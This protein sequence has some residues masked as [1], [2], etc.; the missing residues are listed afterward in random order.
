MTT[1]GKKKKQ[2]I[3]TQSTDRGGAVTLP[4]GVLFIAWGFMLLLGIS[5]QTASSSLNLF[6]NMAIGLGGGL[7][8]AIPI[9]VIWFGSLLCVSA[10]RRVSMYAFSICFLLLLCLQALMTLLLR[11]NDR[12]YPDLMSYIRNLNYLRNAIAPES[13]WEYISASYNRYYGRFAGNAFF[14]GGGAL[15]MLFAWPLH[16]AFGNVGAAVMLFILIAALILALLRLSPVRIIESL[17][18]AARK[19]HPAGKG[20]AV[21]T[22]VKMQT[23]PGSARQEPVPET[24]PDDD[25]D[26]TYRKPQPVWPSQ[27]LELFP[28]LN[29]APEP[30]FIA[31]PSAGMLEDEPQVSFVKATAEPVM[32]RQIVQQ[33]TPAYQVGNRIKETPSVKMPVMTPGKQAEAKPAQQPAPLKEQPAT[34]RQTPEKSERPAVPEKEIRTP[35]PVADPVFPHKNTALTREKPASEEGIQPAVQLSGE[36]VS[37][38]RRADPIIKKSLDGMAKPA[39]VKQIK[40]AIDDYEMPPVRLLIEPPE[41]ELPDTTAEDLA[42]ADKLI[43]TLKSFSIPAYVHDITHGP[44]VTRFAIR[45]S[46]GVNVSRLRSVMD[47]LTIE[48]KAKGEI[49][50]EMPIPGTSFV[51]L[52]VS[53]DRTAKVYLRDVLSSQRMMD[54]TSPTAVALGKDI[55]GTPIVCELMDMPHLLIAGATGSGKSVCINSIIC[56]ML[57]RA[58]PRNVRMVMIDPKFVELQPYNDVP[59]LL[60]PVITDPKKTAAALDYI[61][62]LMDERYQILVDA[63]VRN[64]D[65]YNRKLGP[66]ED[67]LPRII[68]IVDE[69]A[70][71]MTTSGKL[72]EDHIK[73]ITAKARAAGI[74]LIMA[75]QRPSVNIITGVIKANIPGRIAFRVSSSFDSKTILDEVGAEKLLGYGDMLYRSSAREPIRIQGCFVTDKDVEQT[76]QYIRSRNKAEYNLDMMEYVEK[77]DQPEYSGAEEGAEGTDAEFDELLPQAIEMAVEAGQM[78]I[79]MLQRVLRVGYARSGRLIDEMA[80]RGI[81]SGNEGTKPRKTL[82]TRE[83]YMADYEQGNSDMPH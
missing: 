80:R 36:R 50:A 20:D 2:G 64:L 38:T 74:C 61:C 44:T 65:A 52:E 57:Y 49:R 23:D 13:M 56:S 78:S 77:A 45:L 53:N 14:P 55:T 29:P 32:P 58:S 7:Y 5:L 34:A 46:E 11:I 70:D 66:D 31:Q 63:G 60:M 73:R 25:G 69:M 33:A 22:G 40:L 83:Q 4:F 8:P 79:S 51:G 42:R 48:L 1:G 39:E 12:E 35:E 81:I 43:E 15:G 21:P 72:I 6:K 47:N 37:V 30:G 16:L 76:A 54:T 67:P 3:R 75:T 59:H 17:S 10:K 9:A 19:R 62:R 71:L 68:V 26:M 28:E 24:Y 18:A 27:T 82:I 41:S